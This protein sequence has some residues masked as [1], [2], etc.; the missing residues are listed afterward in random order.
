ME[1]RIIRSEGNLMEI[2]MKGEDHTLVNFLRDALWNIKGVK[3][4]GY[5]QKHPLISE[6]R[7]T[8]RTDSI[9]P[10]KAIEQAVDAMKEQIK[11]LK[12]LSKKLE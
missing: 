4:A 8:V 9:K 6:P 10:K 2:E 5:T 1:L 7:I 3:E 11:E 12:I